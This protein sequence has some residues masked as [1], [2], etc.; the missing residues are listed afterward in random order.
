LLNSSAR[1]EPPLMRALLCAALIG[2]GAYA[3]HAIDWLGGSSLAWLLASWG[4]TSLLVVTVMFMFRTNRSLNAGNRSEARTDP[5]TGLANRRQLMEDLAQLT[6]AGSDPR[7]FALFDLD[8]FKAYNDSFGHPAGDS[9]LAELAERLQ[10][11]V[12]PDG[13]AYRLGGDEFCVVAPRTHHVR[14]PIA[15]ASAALCAH[16]DG[17]TIGSS[18]GVVFLPQEADDP[19]AALRLTDRRMY[20]AKSRRPRSAE[21]QMRNVLLRV[22]RE[23][24]PEL[25]RHLRSVA[26]LSIELGHTIH[27]NAEQLD[28]VARAAELHDIGKIAV[29]DAVL[30]KQAPLNARE[31]RIMRNH[32]LIG[33]R[34]L[35]SAPAM[36]PVA[37]LVRATHERW[38]GGG[39]PDGLAEEE[40]PLGS[41]LIAVCDAFVAMT[42]PRPWRTPLTFEAA[43]SEL[44]RCAGMQFDPG[45]VAAFCAFV[46]PDLLLGSKTRATAENSAADRANPR[47][48]H[49]KMHTETRDIQGHSDALNLHED[50]EPDLS[51]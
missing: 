13:S 14:D 48:V 36:T 19:G 38:D 47:E 24:E 8:G 2:Y 7:V 12:A 21:R 40:I 15:T 11:A 42:E 23:R 32:P 35:S 50:A 27:L 29:P 16:G 20:A 9:L 10:I 30:H 25:D 41:R 17:F 1:G 31:W 45:L 49:T 28:E 5:L 26:Q 43:A 18:C 6:E 51:D 44:Q 4:Y 3:L 39:Y 33:E 37:K 34:I 46:Y 22:L